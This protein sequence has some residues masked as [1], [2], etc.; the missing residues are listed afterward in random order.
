MADRFVPNKIGD[1]IS[2]GN[3]IIIDGISSVVPVK[4]NGITDTYDV[5]RPEQATHDAIISDDDYCIF[6]SKK[7]INREAIIDIL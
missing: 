7:C 6:I 4:F 5:C 2:V 3:A 1:Q